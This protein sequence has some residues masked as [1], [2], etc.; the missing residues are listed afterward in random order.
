MKAFFCP[1]YGPPEVFELRN[2]PKPTPK[3]NEILVKV[4]ALPIT[5]GDSRIRALRVPPSFRFMAKIALG[6]KGPRK[7]ILGRYFAG[8]VESIGK[9]VTQFK[10]G[11]KVF[12][13][14]GNKYSTYAEFISVT[15]KESITTIPDNI[16]FKE[17]AATLWGNGTALYFLRKTDINK[18][19][20][21]LINGASGSVGLGAV[22]LAKHF[23]YT[24]TAVC[25]SKNKE[26]VK[27]V[28]ADNVIDYTKEDFTEIESS[29]DIIFDT[30][31][32]HSIYKLSNALKPHGILLHA[33]ATPS[34][35]KEARKVFKGT[36]KRFIGGTFKW[37]KEMISFI[38]ELIVN[39][40]VKP[41]IDSSYSFEEMI[42]A[43]HRVDSG[44]KTG[45]VVVT[46]N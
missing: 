14:T 44:R 24:V 38:R 41:I 46:L 10:I 43:H 28:G 11:D 7:P 22:Q 26:L 20:H 1:S 21:I 36:E 27:S 45:D 32:N 19:Q 30:V 42:K 37:N 29:F 4:K 8:V 13:S 40:K 16:N 5:V 25:S 3:A 15:E 34:V 2:T 12:G 23:G 9:N 6:F 33:V 31:G 18:S 35:T 17:A 39:N